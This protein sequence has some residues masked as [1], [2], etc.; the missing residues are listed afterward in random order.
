MPLDRPLKSDS[1]I[2][3]DLLIVFSLI[4]CS[5]DGFQFNLIWLQYTEDFSD[6]IITLGYVIK[7]FLVYRAEK[8]SS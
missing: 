4:P 6:K 5:H 3:I 1:L 8:E 7:V 2:S